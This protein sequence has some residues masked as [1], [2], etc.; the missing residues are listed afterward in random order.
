[1]AREYKQDSH[2]DLTRDAYSE[3][4][5]IKYNIIMKRNELLMY[6]QDYQFHTYYSNVPSDLLFKILSNLVTLYR[7]IRPMLTPRR[8]KDKYKEY[9]EKINP[10]FKKIIEQKYQ[11]NDNELYKVIDD[12][13]DFI[14]I[15][16]ITDLSID[17]SENK[18]G[19]A[20]DEL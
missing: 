11:P 15:L 20:S 3:Y 14:H 16:G 19:L 10:I 9:K 17:D 7:L 18:G 8:G 2:D 6:L 12:V 1:M 5:L 13:T 4:K